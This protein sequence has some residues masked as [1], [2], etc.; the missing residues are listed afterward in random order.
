M[1]ARTL[2]GKALDSVSWLRF[3]PAGRSEVNWISIPGPRRVSSSSGVRVSSR[4]GF[5][6]VEMMVVVMIF[7]L[8]MVAGVPPFV[9]YVRSNRLETKQKTA[10][11]LQLARSIAIANGIVVRVTATTTGYS[12][13]DPVTAQTIRQREFDGGCQLAINATADFFPW[14][15]ADSQVFNL[16]NVSGARVINLLPTGMVEVQ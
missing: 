7:G 8:L 9:N 11:D 1:T 5:T 15:M 2:L 12:V 4:R 13:T 6:L 16:S 14:G 3:S 10:L